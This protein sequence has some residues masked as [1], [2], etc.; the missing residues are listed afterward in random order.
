MIKSIEL[1][2]FQSHKNTKLDFHPG[3]NVIVGSSRS[4]KT[5]I[6]RALN[7]NRYNKPAGL[8]F[9][10]YWNRDKKKQPIDAFSSTVEFEDV[11]I[12]RNRS[13]EFNGYIGGDKRYE[14]LGQGIP[15]DVETLWNMSEVNIQKQF[16]TPF[17]ISESAAEVAR[18]FN[19]TIHLDKI[20]VVLSNAE[21]KRRKLNSSILENTKMKESLELEI[22][23]MEWIDDV[24]LMIAVA[25]AKQERIL[26]KNDT[27]QM[28]TDALEVIDAEH[29]KLRSIPRNLDKVLKDMADAEALDAKI[30]IKIDVEAN[31]NAFLKT[32]ENQKQTMLGNIAHVRAVIVSDMMDEAKEMSDRKSKNFEKEVSLHELLRAI[33]KN[34][35]NVTLY[36]TEAE[37]LMAQMPKTCPVC[38]QALKGE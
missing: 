5:A 31:L 8:A 16:D 25:E 27:I 21:S 13:S 15:E 10:S 18:F 29:K 38:G 2:N 32:I 36:K 24:E 11:S 20:D 6:L 33:Q 7:W 9:N 37:E 4:G 19:K 12:D 34:R 26:F 35:M 22:S 1:K 30:E 28:I 3:V 17:L 23:K 14:A